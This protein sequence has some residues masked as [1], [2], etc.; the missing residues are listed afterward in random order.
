[1]GF[2]K[3]TYI[4]KEGFHNIYCL[5]HGKK[6]RRVTNSGVPVAAQ[7]ITPDHLRRVLRDVM[8][9]PS[10]GRL[11]RVSLNH[12]VFR[13]AVWGFRQEHGWKSDGDGGP[14]PPDDYFTKTI[15]EYGRLDVEPGLSEAV[16][17]MSTPAAIHAIRDRGRMR[18]PPYPIS[19]D[20]TDK[21]CREMNAVL[22][23][24]LQPK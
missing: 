6:M 7:P 4:I 18:Q 5:E 19:P 14:K 9:A 3:V 20:G 10:N 13:Q 12:E 1:M 8:S 24:I 2:H 15:E 23:W 22:K 17:F 11:S 16:S 21:L